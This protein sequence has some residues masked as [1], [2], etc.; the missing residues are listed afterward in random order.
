MVKS[1]RKKLTLSQLESFLLKAADI[2]RK[3]GMDAV[4][5]PVKWTTRNQRLRV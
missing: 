2:L 4:A 1:K 3:T 5:F